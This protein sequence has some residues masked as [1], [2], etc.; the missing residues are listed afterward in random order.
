MLSVLD[1]EV[2]DA[3]RRTL[4]RAIMYCGRL[5]KMAWYKT[6]AGVSLISSSCVEMGFL[7]I[8]S[9]FLICTSARLMYMCRCSVLKPS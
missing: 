1:L 6:S 7:A 4:S 9:S 3:A 5:G 8:S 2:G